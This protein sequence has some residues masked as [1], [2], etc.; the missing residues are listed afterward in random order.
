M[1]SCPVFQTRKTI[2]FAQ[3]TLTCFRMPKFQKKNSAAPPRWISPYI[4][5]G[6]R[7]F[8]SWDKSRGLNFAFEVGPFCVFSLVTLQN[9]SFEHLATISG[10]LSFTRLLIFLAQ[11]ALSCSNLINFTQQQP[12]QADISCF[13]N[14]FLQKHIENHRKK[15]LNE[16]FNPLHLSQLKNLLDPGLIQGKIQRGGAALFFF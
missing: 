11:N 9:R 2:L 10:R 5:P 14:T 6:S 15:T 7:R 12:F 13:W 4:K 16:K 3:C 1:F 8:L